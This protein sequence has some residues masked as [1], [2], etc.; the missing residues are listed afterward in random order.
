MRRSALLAMAVLLLSAGAHAQSFSRPPAD[1][2]RIEW[3]RRPPWMRP[4]VDGYVYND[5]RW[6]V[7]NVR[8]LAQVVDGS[9]RVVRESFAVVFG[10]V[11]PGGRTFF[12]L[13]AL[14]EGEN[15]QL[16]VTS[17]DLIAHE[18]P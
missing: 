3:A 10:N 15:Y 9:G 13:P 8:V 1:A 11:V 18:G 5:S 16:A 6:R 17:F 14:A 7:G 2:F 12:V 4:G